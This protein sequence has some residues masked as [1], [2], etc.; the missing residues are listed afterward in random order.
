MDFF[1]SLSYVYNAK[2]NKPI[3]AIDPGDSIGIS[4]GA[5]I[6]MNLYTSIN[7]SYDQQFTERT[8]LGEVDVPG[9]YI[10]TGTFSTG[11]SYSIGDDKSITVGIGIG[12][13]ADA[14]DVQVNV[15]LPISF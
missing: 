2:G 10:N 4:L 15:S 1:G 13:T 8:K 11:L 9:S 3:G 14:P 12:L 7:F 5:A 6:S